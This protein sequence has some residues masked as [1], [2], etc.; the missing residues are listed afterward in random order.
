MDK[1]LLFLKEYKWT[2]ICAL[3]ALAF[4]IL[5][6]TIN[7]WRT[8]LLFAIVGVGIFIGLTLDKKGSLKNFF[9]KDR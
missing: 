1:F 5:V 4:V 7:F 8:L 3:I 2:V 6:F 9:G